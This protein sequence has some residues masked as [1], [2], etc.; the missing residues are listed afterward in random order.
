M[1]VGEERGFL[2]GVRAMGDDDPRDV[3]AFGRGQ[4]GGDHRARLNK[5]HFLAEP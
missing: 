2:H 1:D 4:G 3:G 5:A